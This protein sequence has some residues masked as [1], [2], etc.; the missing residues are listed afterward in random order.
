MS[1]HLPLLRIQSSGYRLRNLF[2][3]GSGKVQ[4]RTC[5]IMWVVHVQ[6][7]SS[8]FKLAD[9]TLESHILSIVFY[10]DV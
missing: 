10:N 8:N 3:E 1:L 9:D 2:Q 5:I 4:V 6:C 7:M